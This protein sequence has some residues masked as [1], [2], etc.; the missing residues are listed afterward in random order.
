[1]F[2]GRICEV[3]SFRDWVISVQREHD[4]LLE[5]EKGSF[6]RLE[7]GL[8]GSVV[9]AEHGV[10]EEYVGRDVE[11]DSVAGSIYPGN[12]MERFRY[13]VLGL[14]TDDGFSLDRQPRLRDSAMLMGAE[15]VKR[16][17]T[18][19]GEFSISYLSDLIDFSLAPPEAVVAILGSVQE[20]VPEREDMLGALKSHTR[21]VADE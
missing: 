6:V 13:D 11:D 16:F 17:H 4:E 9:D 14:G 8:V 15:E 18:V 21:R 1:M 10:P 19:E 7:S 12:V 3:K 20:A 2:L 5:V